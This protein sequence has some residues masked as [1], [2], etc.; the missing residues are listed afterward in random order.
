M[1][2]AAILCAGL[3]LLACGNQTQRT[4]FD[5]APSQ[6]TLPGGDLAGEAHS[7][8][9]AEIANPYQGQ[10]AAIT[11][12]KTLFGQ[13]NCAGCHGYTLSG[14]MGPNLSD[15]YWRYGGSP[16]AIYASIAS[17]HP[18]GMPAWR[19]ALP[20]DDIWKIVAYIQSAGGATPAA[21]YQAGLQGDAVASLGEPGAT[22]GAQAVAKGGTSKSGQSATP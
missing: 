9:S 14:G 7:S 3:L 1:K 21:A 15:P 20:P 12:G 17:G 5:R 6:S 2:S 19:D 22:P 10:P 13:M 8:H 16:A 11:D 18:Q 4:E